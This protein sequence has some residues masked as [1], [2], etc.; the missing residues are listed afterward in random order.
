[1][2]NTLLSLLAIVMMASCTEPI[3]EVETAEPTVQTTML[4]RGKKNTPPP[5]VFTP[6]YVDSTD[7][8][9]TYDTS[10]CGYLILRWTDQNR[11]VGAS[12]YFFVVNPQATGC[13]GG[14]FSTTNSLYYQYGWGCSFWTNNTYSVS[15]RYTWRDSANAKIFVYTSKAAT[16]KTGRGIWDCNN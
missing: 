2:K 7:W 9:I 16:V 8:N 1:M 5:I 3:Q 13:A 14:L 6:V 10:L 4:E 15:I 11:P 12:N